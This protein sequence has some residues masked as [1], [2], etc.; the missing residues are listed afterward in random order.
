MAVADM[1]DPVQALAASKPVEA[2]WQ[3]FAGI[4]VETRRY[5]IFHRFP[6]LASMDGRFSRHGRH[7]VQDAPRDRLRIHSLQL[8]V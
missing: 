2:L 4:Y 8:L 3:K 7:V 6:N 5:L 1:M